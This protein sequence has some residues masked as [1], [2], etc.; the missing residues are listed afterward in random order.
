[1]NLFSRTMTRLALALLVEGSL[2]LA[3]I[4]ALPL[5]AAGEGFEAPPTL[6]L[7][8]AALRSPHEG[9]GY[10]MD[11]RVPTDGL[12]SHFTL[13]SDFDTFEVLGVET[14]A[15]R[16]SEIPAIAPGKR[17]WLGGRA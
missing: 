7:E 8:E 1:M 10:R 16:V 11:E 2:V 5:P 13:H 14:L 15:L 12:T 9:P 6:R 4:A 3:V 17:F